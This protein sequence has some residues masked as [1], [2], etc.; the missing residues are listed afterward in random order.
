M[1]QPNLIAEQRETEREVAQGLVGSTLDERYLLDALV[2]QGGF[3]VVFRATDLR[4]NTEVAVKVAKPGSSDVAARFENEVSLS[5]RLSADR[6]I[7]CATDRGTLATAGDF[8][9]CPYLV[10]SFVRGRELDSRLSYHH[11]TFPFDGAVR[12]TRDLLRALEH[13]HERGIVHRDVKPSNVM[14]R[15]DGSAVLIDLGVAFATGEGEEHRSPDLTEE[16]QIVGTKLYMSPEQGLGHRP[17]CSF[18][19]YALGVTLYQVV[20]G[21]PP[22]RAIHDRLLLKHKLTDKIPPVSR[23]RRDTPP[24][25]ADA[26]DSMLA[27]NPDERPSATEALKRLRD[28]HSGPVPAFPKMLSATSPE[29]NGDG[30][31]AD[32]LPLDPVSTPRRRVEPSPTSE[33]NDTEDSDLGVPPSDPPPPTRQVRQGIRVA[34]V[35]AVALLLSVAVGAWLAFI[36]PTDAPPLPERGETAPAAPA[37]PA[38][39]SHETPPTAAPEHPETP[40]PQ[41]ATDPPKTPTT[42]PDDKNSLET[43]V[44]RGPPKKRSPPFK[45]KPEPPKAPSLSESPKTPPPSEPKSTADELRAE[46]KG[47]LRAG[48]YDDCM[49]LANK[50]PD[51]EVAR[52]TSMCKRRKAREDDSP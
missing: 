38:P 16:R 2:G 10:T 17:A 39:I 11:G 32:I 28:L 5:A 45:R 43:P 41:A 29:P 24:A 51:A 52:I 8:D 50:T 27:K 23:F 47:L 6:A 15:D 46:A 26:I 19:I 20:T 44:K 37:S 31:Q 14:V 49:A 36:T 48:R 9:G 42:T 21:S 3:A 35:I 4:M 25:L 12:I 22:L 33:T 34:M 40:T 13:L 30:D 18:D 1:H 7:A